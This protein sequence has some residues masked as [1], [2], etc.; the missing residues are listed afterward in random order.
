LSE[1][2]TVPE[3][4]PSAEAA[5]GLSKL[6]DL[7]LEP[8]SGF[9]AVLRTPGRWWLPLLVSMA[10]HV[11]FSLVWVSKV[12]PVEHARLQMEESKFTRNLPPEQK[13]QQ[14]QGR[15]RSTKV[16]FPVIF[17][18]VPLVLAVVAGAINLFVYRFFYGAEMTFKQSLA[19]HTW[20]GLALAAVTLPLMLVVYAVKGDWNIDPAVILQAN[21]SLLLT[22]GQVAPALYGLAESIDLVSAWTVFLLATGYGVLIRKPTSA[23][24]WGVLVPW[25]LLVLVKLG[26]LALMG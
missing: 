18:L 1:S 22:K 3:P 25:C 10:L 15:A 6:G 5:A 24:L 13:E 17:L 14:I 4:V 20:T 23:A 2:Q 21:L 16:V 7:Y 8:R 12:D 26:F 19:V 11:A 9:T